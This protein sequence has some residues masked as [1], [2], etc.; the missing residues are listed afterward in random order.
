[1]IHE[2]LRALSCLI[3]RHDWIT[4]ALPVGAHWVLG[5]RCLRC[6][7]KRHLVTNG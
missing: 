5:E 7:K 4:T 3:G 1:V 6:P 2:L